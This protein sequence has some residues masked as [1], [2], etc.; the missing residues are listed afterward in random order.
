MKFSQFTE[1]GELS[2]HSP[3][4]QEEWGRI[5]DDAL[6][7][8]EEITFQTSSRKEVLFRKVKQ[9]EWIECCPLNGLNVMLDENTY[10]ICSECKANIRWKYNFCPNC[11]ADM[12]KE[13]VKWK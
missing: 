7:R 13:R 5:T 4:I 1:N 3:I 6:E 10:F 2:F 9:G 8:T 12:R 11:G